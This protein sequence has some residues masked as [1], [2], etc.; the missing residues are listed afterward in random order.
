M[1]ETSNEQYTLKMNVKNRY[2][3]NAYNMIF[4][5]M[6]LFMLHFPQCL[7]RLPN[8]VFMVVKKK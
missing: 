2:I 6:P 3:Q 7:N 4:K 1:I 5:E 8:T